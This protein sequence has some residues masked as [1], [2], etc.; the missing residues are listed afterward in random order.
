MILDPFCGC[1]TTIEV[2]QKS[3]RRWAGIDISSFAIDLIL[4]KRLKL[5]KVNVYGIPQDHRS[6]KKLAR[7]KPFEFES[8]AVTRLPG[9][10]PNTR[11]RADG[12]VDGR[13]TIAK[14]PVNYNS[15]LALAQIKGGHFNL[16]N[17]RDFIH[18]TDRDK[19]ALG[20]YVT[21]DP[22]MSTAAR[23]EAAKARTVT[24]GADRYSRCQVW[25]IAHYFEGRRPHLPTMTDP[26]TGKPLSQGGLFPNA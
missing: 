1:G 26:Y 16:S 25:P 3:N 4:E 8:W 6:A 2:A 24:I 17:L 10:V 23:T 21:L 22:V 12:G 13:A 15:R 5:F 19:A 11:Q 18:V 20:V 9:F 14:K 7:E